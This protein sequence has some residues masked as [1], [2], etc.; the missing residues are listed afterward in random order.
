MT[1]LP[2][3]LQEPVLGPLATK[4]RGDWLHEATRRA[5]QLR[6]QTVTP[7]VQAWGRCLVDAPL[8]C[9]APGPLQAMLQRLAETPAS[10]HGRLS[11]ALAY[12]VRRRREEAA[13]LDAS[14]AVLAVRF[15][16]DSDGFAAHA[17]RRL[18][19]ALREG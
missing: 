19:D 18:R 11:Q 5:A 15:E 13:R 4:C 1:A 3:E 8:V 2:D 10:M 14:L 16:E 12:A 17:A 9:A 6:L 7:D